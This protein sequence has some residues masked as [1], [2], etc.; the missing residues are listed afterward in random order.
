MSK[1]RGAGSRVVECF[2]AIY[3]IEYTRETAKAAKELAEELYET[4]KEAE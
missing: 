3:S 1:A 4:F 2:T